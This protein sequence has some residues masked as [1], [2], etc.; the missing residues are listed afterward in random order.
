MFLLSGPSIFS[1]VESIYHPVTSNHC[2]VPLLTCGQ[3]QKEKSF[4]PALQFNTF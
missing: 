3:I 1:K 4:T 2:R